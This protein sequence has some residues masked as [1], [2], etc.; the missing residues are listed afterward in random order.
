MNAIEKGKE[1]IRD[2][3]E[4]VSGII[5]GRLGEAGFYNDVMPIIEQTAKAYA[6]E[7]LEKLK[8]LAKEKIECPTGDMLCVLWDYDEIIDNRIKELKN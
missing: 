7:E 4:I 8:G 3:M 5:S 6:V 1:D 2:K